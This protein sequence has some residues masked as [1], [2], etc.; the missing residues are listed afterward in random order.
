MGD[1]IPGTI[2]PLK[3]ESELKYPDRRQGVQKVLERQVLSLS[4]VTVLNPWVAT[5]LG[6][7]YQIFCISDIYTMIHKSSKIT[8]MK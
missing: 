6:Y 5:P 3:G 4:G 8:V 7:V 2:S 1:S